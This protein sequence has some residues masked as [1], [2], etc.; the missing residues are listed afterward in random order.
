VDNLTDAEKKRLQR[1]HEIQDM[2]KV[3]KNKS[4][5]CRK[6]MLN[7]ATVN[8]YIQGDPEILCRSNKRSSLD[9][10]KDFIIRSISEGTTQSEVARQVKNLGATAGVG[11]IRS[12]V[13]SVVNQYQLNVTKYISSPNGSIPAAKVKAEHITRKGIFNYLW[14]NGE[15]TSEHH[16]FLWNKYNV[17]SELKQCIREFREV[18]NRKNM[19]KL[20]LF[21]EKYKHSV[22]KELASFANGLEKDLDAV[23][24]AVAS[25]LSNGFVEGTNSKV[26]MVKR[27]MYGRCGKKLLS[28]K[29][30][31]EP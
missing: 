28:A 6:F 11:N 25:E 10:Y 30:M 18:F 4:E 2:A 21:I 3:C 27:T 9:Q 24:N 17:L 12:Y 19:P 22:I 31:Y 15:L 13:I 20:Y 16:E 5:I 26:K 8:K 29:L 7:K 1:I 23:E 14:M